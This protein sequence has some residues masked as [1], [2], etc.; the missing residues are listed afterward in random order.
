[1][2]CANTANLSLK[3]STQLTPS[4]TM[5]EKDQKDI[6]LIIGLGNPILGDDGVGWKIVTEVESILNSREFSTSRYKID[7]DYLSIGGLSLMEKMIGY[8]NVLVVDSI[9]TGNNPNGTVY[10]LPLSKIPKV[11]TSHTTSVHDTSLSNAIEIGKKMGFKL[12]VDVW[13]VAVEAENTHTFSEKLSPEIEEMIPKA[14]ELILSL[15]ENNLGEEKIILG[16]VNFPSV[17]S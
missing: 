16:D 8:K 12:P 14:V 2:C 9:F 17:K 1:M 4:A 11:S 15:L 7:L 10:S 3:G 5:N 6:I 13:I